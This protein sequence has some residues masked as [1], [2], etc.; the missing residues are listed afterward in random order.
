MNTFICARCK[1][2]KINESNITTG[3]GTGETGEKVCFECCGIE[4]AN[5][6]RETGKLTGYYCNGE[7]GKYYFTNW[8]GTLK[9][10]VYYSRQSWHNFAG[11]NGRTDFWLK[12]EGKEFHGVQIGHFSQIA[13]IKQLKSKIKAGTKL[14]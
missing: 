7:D 11:K 12:F 10:P 4:D 3:Y 14:Q 2:E 13:T 8:P 9:L 1:K 6:L 5:T